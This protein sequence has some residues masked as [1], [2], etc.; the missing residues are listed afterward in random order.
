MA[1]KKFAPPPKSNTVSHSS[2]E[3][4]SRKHNYSDYNS[5][6]ETDSEDEYYDFAN[7]QPS[8]FYSETI[9]CITASNVEESNWFFIQSPLLYDKIQKNIVSSKKLYEKIEYYITRLNKKKSYNILMKFKEMVSEHDIL[10]INDKFTKTNTYM[11]FPEPRFDLIIDFMEDSAHTDTTFKIENV[12]GT[13]NLDIAAMLTNKKLGRELIEKNLSAGFK[14][15]PKTIQDK[16]IRNYIEVTHKDE[17]PGLVIQSP[18]F[19]DKFG[20]EGLKF[21]KML[22][23]FGV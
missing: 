23:L 9:D 21:G 5:T 12:Q 19:L 17:P 15:T 18:D 14:T 22:Y 2:E 6:N 3:E 7:S 10:E 8:E 13:C 4:D 11:F 20:H 16:I 1:K